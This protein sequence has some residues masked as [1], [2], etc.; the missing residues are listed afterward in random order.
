MT[1]PSSKSN[2]NGQQLVSITSVDLVE[3]VAQG[4]T[5]AQTYV[6]IDLRIHVGAS[7][8]TP[9]VGDQW[10]VERFG[11]SWCLVGK[12]PANTTDL[13]TPPAAGQT[14]LGASG[15]SAGPTQLNGSLVSA[16]APL[17]LA[18]TDITT[19]PA[20]SV[21]AG[22]LVYDGVT[23]VVS[24]G[25]IWT[26]LASGTGT[27]N[28]VA[29]APNNGFTGTVSS[30]PAT[31]TITM[32]TTVTGMIIGN[33]TAISAAV[34]GTNYTSPTGAEALTN[35]T[36]AATDLTA[37][38]NLFPASTM[39]YDLS[40]VS[41]GAVTVRTVGYGDNPMGIRL[42]RACTLNSVTFR[43]VT[44]DV[45]GNLVCHLNRNGTALSGSSTNLIYYSQISG[46]T[47]TF[48]HACSAGDIITVYIDS[49]GTTPGVGLVAD[50]TGTSTP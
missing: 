36:V 23:P 38:T 16:N 11:L 15:P 29:V 49:V 22:S 35:K 26:P 2:P 32:G 34:A 50:I 21:P 47:S 46:V 28:T 9:A 17:S 18:M 31:P 6:P 33:G 20:S 42:Q 25:N 41:C 14:Q 3:M 45:S 24:D 27:V 19:T 10:R 1:S 8:V 4:Y 37:G 7:L 48:S 44:A 39:V 43:G 5:R 13:L 12:L 40:I 30:D